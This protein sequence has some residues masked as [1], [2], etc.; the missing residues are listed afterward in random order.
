MAQISSR[1]PEFNSSDLI[2]FNYYRSSASYRVRCVLELKGLPYTYK[3]V[4]LLK[5]E[6]EQH[7][8]EFLKLNPMGQVPTL[9]H[10]GQ[11]L[12]QSL[13]IAEY[14]EEAFPKLPPVLPK[15]LLLKAKVREFCEII[16]CT[17]PMQNLTTLN[18]LKTLYGVEEKD[19]LTWLSFWFDKAFFALE[20]MINLN[21]A[22][23]GRFCFGDTPTLADCFLAPQFYASQ[24][25]GYSMQAYPRILQVMETL[26]QHSAFRRAHPHRQID[27]PSELVEP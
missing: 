26:D 13:P 24:R 15:D 14:L 27:T 18:R 7:S 19:R 21:P 16:N 10:R 1:S 23:P 17:Q 2:L 8:P 9:L 4:H 25:M 3:P 12:S 22:G 6:G 5:G 20:K 11:A